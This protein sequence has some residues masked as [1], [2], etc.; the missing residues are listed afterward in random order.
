M[1]KIVQIDHAP[2][3]SAS[4]WELF[5]V[6]FK[7]GDKEWKAHLTQNQFKKQTILEELE[8][9]IYDSDFAEEIFKRVEKLEELAYERG[10]QDE[11]E[12]N[13]GAGL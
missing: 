13:A 1:K 10:A 2:K 6:T 3:P 9:M 8:A 7:E 11:V 12:S 4:H 5:D